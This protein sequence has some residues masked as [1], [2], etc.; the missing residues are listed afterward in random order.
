MKPYF[1]GGD[2][3]NPADNQCLYYN[4]NDYGICVS[5]SCVTGN[6]PGKQRGVPKFIEDLAINGGG[7]KPTDSPTASATI[8]DN[9]Q[10]TAVQSLLDMKP[11]SETD[12]KNTI[13]ATYTETNRTM[14]DFSA[15]LLLENQSGKNSNWTV[16]IDFSKHGGNRTITNVTNARLFTTGKHVYNVVS[17][18]EIEPDS[19]D[20]V[21]IEGTFR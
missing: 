17:L 15:L 13:K 11:I 3:H 2:V 6:H 5:E 14:T 12:K 19:V 20:S 4:A 9:V 7:G 1:V 18:F 16:T 21:I 8:A 10:Q